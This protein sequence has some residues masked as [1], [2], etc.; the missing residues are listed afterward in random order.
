[1]YQTLSES[2]SFCKRYDKNILVCFWFTV[3]AA[4]HLQNANAKFHKVGQRHYSGE[5]ENVYISVPQIYS[6]QHVPNFIIIRQ[7]LQTV[8]PK[9][10]WCVIFRF[11]L[12]ICYGQN[13][14]KLDTQYPIPIPIPEVVSFVGPTRCR[15]PLKLALL[16]DIGDPIR[17]PVVKYD[18]QISALQQHC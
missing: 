10:F 17:H 9:T 12:Y 11:T 5:A 16:K 14:T 18:T 15:L 1:M 2:A 3:L 13:D 8:C 7:V 4:V 6:G